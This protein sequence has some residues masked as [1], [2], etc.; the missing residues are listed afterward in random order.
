MT[1]FCNSTAESKSDVE[2]YEW[3]NERIR[4]CQLDV[5]KSPEKSIVSAAEKMTDVIG[6]W[7]YFHHFFQREMPSRFI[8]INNVSR[9]FDE[10]LKYLISLFFFYSFLWLVST[11]F[12]RRM[13]HMWSNNV[14]RQYNWRRRWITA[15]RMHLCQDYG[16]HYIFAVTRK[17]EIKNHENIFLCR[18]E[19]GSLTSTV[20]NFTS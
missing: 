1:L 6:K 10:R 12:R 7:V 9:S 5:D 11:W 19:N 17:N 3:I 20:S 15:K 18:S 8:I 4:I 13:S 16:L 2:M 14:R